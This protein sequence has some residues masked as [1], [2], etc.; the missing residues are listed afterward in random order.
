MATTYDFDPLG[1]NPL[2]RITGEDHVLTAVNSPEFQVIIPNFAPFYAN[3]TQALIFKQTDGTL[4]ELKE[5]MD[6][7]LCYYFADASRSLNMPIYGGFNIINRALSGTVTAVYRTIGGAWVAS[8]DQIIKALSD[9]LLNPRLVYWEQVINAPQKFPVIDHALD[10]EDLTNLAQVRDAILL[11]ATKIA[12][13]VVGAP[14]AHVEDYIFD[15]ALLGIGKTP[16][17]PFCTDDE[18]KIGESIK[19]FLNPRGGRLLVEEY[20]R[21]Y[22]DRRVQKFRSDKM[23]I[24]GSYA[25][26][27]YV[28]NATPVRKVGATTDAPYAGMAFVVMGWIR[29]T[30]GDTHAATIDWL[31]DIRLVK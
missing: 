8:P 19:T 9:R 7:H 28:E 3:G 2:N 4:R 26:R 13:K 15:R 12:E 20:L 22:E 21:G 6:Y 14:I 17:A 31:E 30:T 16:N 1:T 10:V 29:L 24:T 27:D 18:A 23:P 5:G 25:I 11:V